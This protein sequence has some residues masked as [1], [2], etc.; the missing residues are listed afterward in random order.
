M[1]VQPIGKSRNKGNNY[2]FWNFVSWAAIL[3]IRPY[4]QTPNHATAPFVFLTQYFVFISYFLLLI[5]DFQ[6]DHL[7]ASRAGR[8]L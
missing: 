3:I 5:S 8:K 2:D 6:F 1:S 7:I 4:R